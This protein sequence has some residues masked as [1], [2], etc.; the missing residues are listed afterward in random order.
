M[1]K[2]NRSS[3]VIH[4]T[5]LGSL[6]LGGCSCNLRNN[7]GNKSPKTCRGTLRFLFERRENFTCAGK[8]VGWIS[9][10]RCPERSSGSDCL[11]KCGGRQFSEEETVIVRLRF[12]I[13]VCSVRRRNVLPPRGCLED[14]FNRCREID[15]ALHLLRK[16]TPAPTDRRGQLRLPRDGCKRV[17]QRSDI[18]HVVNGDAAV[19][20]G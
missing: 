13:S 7:S 16:R 9:T 8:I 19:A 6:Q 20:V 17:G 15:V 11:A 1:S 12:F 5:F 10:Y 2:R 4:A 18:I 14:A 3:E